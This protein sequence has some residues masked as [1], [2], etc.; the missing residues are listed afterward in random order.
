[1][2]IILAGEQDEVAR[3]LTRRWSSFDGHLMTPKDLSQP[4]WRHRPGFRN[5]RLP[6]GQ[7]ERPG[8]P[9]PDSSDQDV[10]VV[11]GRTVSVERIDGVLTRLAGVYEWELAHIVPGDRA[12]V[13]AEM[14]AFLL[15]WLSELDC[16]IL[17]RPTPTCLS[18]PGWRQEQWINFA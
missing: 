14:T 15:S 9:S 11:D 5:A 17:N 1:M 4:G 13:S 10:A 2:L 7:K 3:D 16:P 6:R 18:G 12:Y 8:E